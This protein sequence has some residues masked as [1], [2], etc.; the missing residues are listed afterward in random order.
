MGGTPKSSECHQTCTTFPFHNEHANV[1]LNNFKIK[2]QTLKLQSETTTGLFLSKLMV[3][4]GDEK[5]LQRLFN[6]LRLMTGTNPN[7]SR[8]KETT[9]GTEAR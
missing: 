4:V 8:F 1:H 3:N 9:D 7:S 5:S 2:T 6:V